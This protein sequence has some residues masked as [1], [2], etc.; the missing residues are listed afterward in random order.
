MA[1]PAHDRARPDRAGLLL[2]AVAASMW[3]TWSLFLR[4]S[5]LDGGLAGALVFALMGLLLLPAALRAPAARWDRTAVLLLAAS[6]VLDALNVVTFFEALEETTVAVATLTHYLTP[7]LIALTA[8]WIEGERVPGAIGWAA[9]A[10]GGLLL[11]L[12][13]WEAHGPILHGALFGAAS[14]VCYAGNVFVVRRLAPR[15]GAE[16]AVSY[17]A[18]FGAVLLAPYAAPHVTNVGGA[19][20]A[21]MAIGSLF[22]GS[23]AGTMFVRGLA[24]VGSARAAVLTFAEPMVA[25]TVGWI[26]WGEAL[27]PAAAVGAALIVAAGVGVS[28]ARPAR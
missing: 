4:P 8:P 11:V 14:A 20:L 16:R 17:H 27:G 2:V 5:H 1:E 13:P 9:V 23:I 25:V 7:I 6:T 28:R 21:R 3:G 18:L 19:A 22:L 12:A 24:R 10:S 15:I 26:A